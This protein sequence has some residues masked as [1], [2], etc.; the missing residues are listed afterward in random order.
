M[1]SA[2]YAGAIGIKAS[3][4]ATSITT[5]HPRFDQQRARPTAAE[6]NGDE[7]ARADQL[8]VFNQPLLTEIEIFADCC[9]RET[10]AR[11][12]LYGRFNF[13]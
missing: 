8:L 7:S 12:L 3:D 6:E 5:R 2:G 10:L 11:Y 13:R 4:I 9:S 1:I